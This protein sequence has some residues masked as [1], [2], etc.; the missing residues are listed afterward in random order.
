M[1]RLMFIMLRNSSPESAPGVTRGGRQLVAFAFTALVALGILVPVDASAD[2]ITAK[3]VARADVVTAVTSAVNGDTVIIPAGTASW[4]NALNVTKAITLQGAGIGQT[5]LRDEIS[6]T[7]GGSA[8]AMLAVTLVSNLTTRITGL[9][10]RPGFRATANQAGIV[11]IAGSS[12][13][14]GRARV[15]HCYFNRV[16]NR[17]GLFITGAFGVVDNCIFL[18]SPNQFA[19]DVRHENY[20]GQSYGDG[21]W[22]DAPHFGTDKFWYVEDCVVNQPNALYEM[23]DSYG[24]ARWV[25]R[26]NSI[27]NSRFATHGTESTGRSRGTRAIEIYANSVSGNG[28]ASAALDHRSGTALIYSN[29]V[30]SW[31]TAF[32]GIFTGPAFRSTDA[33]TPWGGADGTNPWDLNDDTNNPYATGT[34]TGGG[35]LTLVDSGASWTTNQWVGCTLANTTSNTFSEITANTTN[36]ITV[37]GG[38]FRSLGFSTG[39]GYAIRR[40]RAI[41]DQPGVGKGD[42]ININSPAWPNQMLEPI[43]AWNNTQN[44]LPAGYNG[45]RASVKEGVH[46]FNNKAMPG[47]V[48]YPYPHPLRGDDANK[49]TAK[50]A[51]PSNLVRT[52]Y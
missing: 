31:N 47:Y 44:G 29:T 38:V 28:V 8:A 30:V 11:Y 50:P 25:A 14:G 13:N 1:Y 12:T 41:L 2:V 51:P 35:A 42:L 37:R 20:G 21:S 19:L 48:A 7:A 3:S 45:L 32:V 34:A 18:L 16:I 46:Y 33:F 10:F 4:T 39:N 36:T 15:D 26:Y 5:I 9:E 27:T 17:A 22:A 40:V 6:S 49:V 43:Y 24:G 23:I 52:N